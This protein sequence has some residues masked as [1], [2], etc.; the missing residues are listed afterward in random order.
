MKD[1]QLLDTLRWIGI[2]RRR[3]GDPHQV[4]TMLMEALNLQVTINESTS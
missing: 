1:Y 3:L 2:C 4:I